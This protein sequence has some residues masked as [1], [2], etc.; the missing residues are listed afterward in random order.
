MKSKHDLSPLQKEETKVR[1]L[2]YNFESIFSSLPTTQQ[3]QAK[4]LQDSHGVEVQNLNTGLFL[5]ARKLSNKHNWS[6]SFTLSVIEEYKRFVILAMYSQKSTTPPP[7]IDD[8]WHMHILFQTEYDKFV[9]EVLGFDF[10]HNP[11]LGI[12]EHGKIHNEGFHDVLTNYK[13]IFG[14]DFPKEIWSSERKNKQKEEKIDGDSV[15]WR[16]DYRVG[17]SS[18]CSDGISI[19]RD[20]CGERC[21]D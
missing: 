11:G 1:I 13:N 4:N 10:Y 19:D 14:E 15:Y 7:W 3:T 6:W 18:D 16:S 8:I 2:N 17:E 9:E 5:F 12:E 21:F 20:S